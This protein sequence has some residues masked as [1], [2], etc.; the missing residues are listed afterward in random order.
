[1]GERIHPSAEELSA[2]LASLTL[3]YKNLVEIRKVWPSA[4]PALHQ[5]LSSVAVV[6]AALV[7]ALAEVAE[8]QQRVKVLEGELQCAEDEIEMMEENES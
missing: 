7:E 3:Q 5:T 4:Y 8:L 2:A 6:R 1:M